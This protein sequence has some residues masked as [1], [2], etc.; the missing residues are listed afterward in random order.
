MQKYR[1]QNNEP[2][3]PVLKIKELRQGICDNSS[4]L[5][6]SHISSEYIIHNGD[7]IF[8]WS[9]TLLVD[10]WTGGECGLNQHLFKVTSTKYEKWFYYLW[11]KHHLDN[12]IDIAAN[13]ATTMGHIKRSDLQSSIVLVPPVEEYNHISSIITPLFN[14]AISRRIENNELS[15]LRNILLTKLLSNDTNNLDSTL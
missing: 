14:E 7:V 9:G 2:S 12:F 15:K 5:C 6:S 3:L 11:T 10:F 8:S 4:D 1:P 13:K